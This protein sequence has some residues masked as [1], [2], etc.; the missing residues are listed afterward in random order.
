MK[1]TVTKMKNILEVLSSRLDKAEYQISDLEEKV[2]ENTQSEKRQEK[3]N[4]KK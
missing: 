4:Q 1:N 3:R 2:A